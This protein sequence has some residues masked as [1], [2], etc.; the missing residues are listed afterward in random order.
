MP[1][2]WDTNPDHVFNTPS[3]Q[4]PNPVPDGHDDPTNE[5][6]LRD[7]S[8]RLRFPAYILVALVIALLALVAMA[9][10]LLFAPG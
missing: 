2:L 6:R 10:G 5:V 8:G 7:P 4:Q 1:D 9:A 3:E